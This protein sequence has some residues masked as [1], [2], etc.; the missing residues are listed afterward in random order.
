LY[1]KIVVVLISTLMVLTLASCGVREKVNDKISEKVTEGVI[2]KATGGAG[3]VDI[4]GDKLTIKGEDG[5]ELTIGGT[6]W[7][8]SGAASM[9]PKVKN[10]TVVSAFN[11]EKACIIILEKVTEQDYAD[12]VDELKGLGFTNDAFTYSAEKS[13][14]YTATS[15]NGSTISVTY[16]GGDETISISFED[17]SEPTEGEQE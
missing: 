14:S 6:E 12:Y 16:N 1:K 17:K 15:E 8:D 11:A 10:G 13:H 2:N 9:I 3:T 7:P 4:D 5:E